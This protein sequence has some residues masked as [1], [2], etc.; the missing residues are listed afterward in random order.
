M[1][2]GRNRKFGLLKPLG[3]SAPRD[4]PDPSV[5]GLAGRRLTLRSGSAGA[6]PGGPGPTAGPRRPRDFS[7]DGD[8]RLHTHA[9]EAVPG[10]PSLTDLRRRCE[11]VL[12]RVNVGELR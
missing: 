11:A 7:V 2:P 12:P 6:S 10:P 5:A 9:I 4:T 3:G 8:G 1:T